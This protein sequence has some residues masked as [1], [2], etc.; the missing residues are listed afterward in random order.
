MN[1][2]KD[3]L[4]HKVIPVN[5][6]NRLIN[7]NYELAKEFSDYV[8]LPLLVTLKFF[9][10]FGCSRVLGLRS[11]LKDYPCD[12]RGKIGIT[13]WKLKQTHDDIHPDQ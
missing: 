9:K 1:N 12:F 11:F 7:R 5:K 2:L 6:G 3:L 13:Y 8:G 10:K 4:N